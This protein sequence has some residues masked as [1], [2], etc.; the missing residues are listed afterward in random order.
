MGAIVEYYLKF[1][2]HVMPLPIFVAT[3]GAKPGERL[4]VCP[5]LSS[6]VSDYIFKKN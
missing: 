1:G 5:L 2:D 3:P 4:G 6:G